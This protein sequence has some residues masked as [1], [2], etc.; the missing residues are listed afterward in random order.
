MSSNGSRRDNLWA[1]NPHCIW[2]GRLTERPLRG[3]I[4]IPTGNIATLDHVVSKWHQRIN[5]DA[6]QMTVLA[7]A[8][9]NA[10]RGRVHCLLFLTFYRE[11]TRQ[12]C[13]PRLVPFGKM[14]AEALGYE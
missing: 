13:N 14:L 10:E 7:C 8:D 2:C 4:T 6:E 3:A 1:I 5:P 11:E 12:I 9:C